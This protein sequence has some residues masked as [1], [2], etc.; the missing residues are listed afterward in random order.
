MNCT[1]EQYKSLSWNFSFQLT[2][3]QFNLELIY[4]SYNMV[5]GSRNF[6]HNQRNVN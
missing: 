3:W 5:N 6:N 2:D 4:D 1:L